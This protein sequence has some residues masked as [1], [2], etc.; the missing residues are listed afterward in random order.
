MN[1][2]YF[3]NMTFLESYWFASAVSLQWARPSYNEKWL[4]GWEARS[5]S[6]STNFSPGWSFGPS[7]SCCSMNGFSGTCLLCSLFL[8]YPCLTSSDG[9]VHWELWW[10]LFILISGFG[11]KAS[12]HLLS[13]TTSLRHLWGSHPP[14]SLCWKWPHDH[15]LYY[16]AITHIISVDGS[17]KEIR[18]RLSDELKV[19][20]LPGESNSVL[21]LVQT[22]PTWK[23]LLPSFPEPS[24]WLIWVKQTTLVQSPS[25][26]WL[27]RGNN[28]NFIGWVLLLYSLHFRDSEVIFKIVEV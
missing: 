17:H 13:W 11:G 10:S 7:I 24:A 12:G 20:R 23:S 5:E 9:M 1:Y 16:C 19:N 27:Q 18:T 26:N 22:F 21:P 14:E 28:N 15:P 3:Q 6:V 4:P 25:A 2:S 8:K